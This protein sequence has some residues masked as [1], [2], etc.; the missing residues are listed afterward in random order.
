MDTSCRVAAL[1]L[2]DGARALVIWR[3]GVEPLLLH[4]KRFPVEVVWASGEF[5]SWARRFG[6]LLSTACWE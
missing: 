1:N 4:V 3:A 2:R 6:G 5:A